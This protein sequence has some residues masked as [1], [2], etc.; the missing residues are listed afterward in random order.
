VTKLIICRGPAASGKSTWSK[1]V[2][3]DDP[4]FVRVS[5]DDIRIALFNKAWG[6]DEDLVTKV[7]HNAIRNAL[8]AGKNVISDNTNVNPKL[9][10]TIAWIG[11]EEGAEVELRN[12]HTPLDVCKARNAARDRVVPEN[13]L[14][15]QYSR[16]IKKYTLPDRPVDF[17][18]YVP[19]EGVRDIF[20][21]DLDGTVAHIDED[22]PRS[23]YEWSRVGEDKP[24]EVMRK[25]LW[26]IWLSGVDIIYLSGR[27][28]SCRD[29]TQSW[30]KENLFPQGDLHMRAANDNRKDW[31]VKGELFDKHIRYNYNV[32][33]VFDDRLQVVNLWKKMGLKVLNVS[34]LDNGDF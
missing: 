23:P 29:E 16:A 12:F 3:D 10:N 27:D 9:A 18:P 28:D 15:D 20:L 22:N 25:L 31:I 24:D 8:K 4:T 14:E 13:V 17:E 33:G 7:E 11:Y 1:S 6:V 34:G 21:C 2:V 19:V 5:R 32:R 30:L 26:A